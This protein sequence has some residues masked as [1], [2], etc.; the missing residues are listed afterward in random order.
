MTGP[1]YPVW[2]KSPTM[3][4]M[5]RHARAALRRELARAEEERERLAVVIAY[6]NER[7]KEADEDQ[8][9]AEKPAK[10]T[11]ARGPYSGM[12]STKAGEKALEDH[13]AP[14]KTRDLFEAITSG[15]ARIKNVEGL[16]KS[17]ARSKKFVRTGRGEWGLARW[18]IPRQEA[19]VGR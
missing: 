1:T 9:R 13:G 11:S 14:M 5:D 19:D 17:L 12:A 15:G 8:P 3:A 6:L 16:Y 7:L 18:P 4:T 2:Y 10:R